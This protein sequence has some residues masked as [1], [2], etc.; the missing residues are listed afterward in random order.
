M[1][2]KST[3]VDILGEFIVNKIPLTFPDNI[4]SEADTGVKDICTVLWLP[5]W[6]KG[7]FKVREK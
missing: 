5:S 4:Q 1:F 7:T 2:D 6:F 3:E